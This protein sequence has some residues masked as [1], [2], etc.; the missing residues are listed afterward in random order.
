[1]SSG[2]WAEWEWLYEKWRLQ[3]WALWIVWRVESLSEVEVVYLDGYFLVFLKGYFER[4]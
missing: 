4:M 2:Y 3:P 1:M